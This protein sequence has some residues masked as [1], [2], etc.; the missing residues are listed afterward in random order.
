[1]FTEMLF[2]N[3]FDSGKLSRLWNELVRDGEMPALT[4]GDGIVNTAGVVSRKGRI[5]VILVHQIGHD[6]ESPLS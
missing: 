1:M 4:S 6:S 3:A 5:P 2:Q